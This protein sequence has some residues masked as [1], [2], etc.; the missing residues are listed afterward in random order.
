[1]V[2]L[3]ITAGCQELPKP[4]TKLT[5]DNAVLMSPATAKKFGVSYQIGSTGGEHGTVHA[6]VVELEHEGRKLRG[7][8]WILPGHAEDCVTLHL[9][10][11][12]TR[13]GKVGTNVGFNANALLT[14][15]AG[16]QGAGLRLRATGERYPLACTQ[17]HHLMEGRH[18]L[19]SATLPEYRKN[20][21][22]VA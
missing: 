21:N 2:A 14:S 8:A 11:G 12:R 10:Y 19:R 15:S 22:L 13:A 7:P 16:L 18:L 3:P 17:F 20:P 5:W 4:L 1:M 6:D 9:G